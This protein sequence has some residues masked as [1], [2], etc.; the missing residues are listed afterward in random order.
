MPKPAVNGLTICSTCGQV[1]PKTNN[2]IAQHLQRQPSI[3][4]ICLGS[5]DTQVGT[6]RYYETKES[7]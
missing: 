3:G 7:K 4:E 2:I 5:G 1:V 6:V